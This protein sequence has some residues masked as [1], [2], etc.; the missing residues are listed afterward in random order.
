MAAV[1]GHL[2]KNPAA[3][4]FIPREAPR[5]QKPTMTS[6][7]VALLF[8]VLQPRELAICM[9]AMVAGMRPSEIFGLKWQHVKSDHFEI[10]QRL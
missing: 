2:G 9:L 5:P 4:L 10:E 6:G 7:Q 1:D 3:L 8:S